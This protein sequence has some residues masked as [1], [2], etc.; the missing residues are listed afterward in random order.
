MG[1]WNIKL[2]IINIRPVSQG[3]SEL[4]ATPM[5]EFCET[6]LKFSVLGIELSFS[7]SAIDWKRARW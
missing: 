6:Y 3:Y 4:I 5:A 7:E 2:G 1:F